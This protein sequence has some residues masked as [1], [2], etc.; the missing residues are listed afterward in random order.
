MSSCLNVI[1]FE[2]YKIFIVGYIKA[3][4]KRCKQLLLENMALLWYFT[5]AVS[6]SQLTSLLLESRKQV[7]ELIGN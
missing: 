1:F 5:K 7:E 4:F 3:I 6:K 2:W